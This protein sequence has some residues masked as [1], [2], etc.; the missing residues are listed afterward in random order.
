MTEDD[1]L[2]GVTLLFVYNADS[3]LMNALKDYIHK[4]VSPATYPCSLCALTY[5][6]L[7]MKGTWARFIDGLGVPV[8][9]LHRDEL[10]QG[11]G[12]S[13]IPLPAVLASDGPDTSVLIA[14]DEIDAL[15]TLEELE[16]LVSTTVAG[17]RE[18][19]S[20]D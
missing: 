14:A 19:R 10:R 16:A 17:L 13:G 20:R 1:P 2:A 9:F 15:G 4:G 6:G 5:G 7:G 11:Y 18:E 12:V 3:G 8:E